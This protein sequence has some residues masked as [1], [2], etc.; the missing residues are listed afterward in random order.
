MHPLHKL[1]NN[2]CLRYTHSIAGNPE[3]SIPVVP[4]LIY[5]DADILK[6][7]S[8]KENRGKSGIYE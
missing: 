5:H 3:P 4:I 8:V 6:L 7:Q 1:Y 2:L